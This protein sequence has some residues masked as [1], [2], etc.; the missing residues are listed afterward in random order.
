MSENPVQAIPARFY[1]ELLL[2]SSVWG[3]SFLFLRVAAPEMGPVFLVEMRVASGLLVMLPMCFLLGKWQEFRDN[4]LFGVGPGNFESA[5]GFISEDG[6][7]RPA[8]NTYLEIA[9]EQGLVGLFPAVIF[10]LTVAYTLYRAYHGA[11]RERDRARIFGIAVGLGLALTAG[12]QRAIEDDRV[13][14]REDL[15]AR[16]A[17]LLDQIRS[18][19]A[20]RDKLGEAEYAR[21]REEL[22]GLAA[23]VL[24]DLEALE[25]T[26]AE[27][28]AVLERACYD[29]HSN[30]TVWPW[31]TYV[32]PFSL[33]AAHDVDEGREY[34]NFS[35]WD[36]LDEEGRRHAREE[37]WEEVDQIL[38]Q[39]NRF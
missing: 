34:L 3:F 31:Y 19:D 7:L 23:K 6:R 37:V 22:V 28:L 13:A 27:V 17:S 30:E 5:T 11:R 2:L 39:A 8:H 20:D 29:C 36:R 18:L 15:T 38:E 35:E 32:A 21:R 10:M 14:R 16:K 4:W 26:P 24:A 9:S 12:G 33:L 1:V 25:A